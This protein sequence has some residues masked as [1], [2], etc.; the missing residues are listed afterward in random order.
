[1][2]LEKGNNVIILNVNS[3]MAVGFGELICDFTMKTNSVKGMKL[4]RLLLKGRKELG[5]KSSTHN[6]MNNYMK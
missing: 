3:S 5:G 2:D 6:W 1:M 4:P